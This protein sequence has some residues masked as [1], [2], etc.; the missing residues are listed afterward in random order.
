MKDS[1]GSEER[2]ECRNTEMGGRRKRTT[3]KVDL[4]K[5]RKEPYIEWVEFWVE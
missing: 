5:E 3:K 1:V 2:Q 4:T